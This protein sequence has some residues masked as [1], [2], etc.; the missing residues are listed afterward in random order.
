MMTVYDDIMRTIIDLPPDQLL[1]LDAWRLSLGLS[2]A[3]AVRRAVSKLLEAERSQASALDASFG[4]LKGRVEDG[5]V[6]QE[7]LRAEWDDR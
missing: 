5:L 4:L 1:A 2:R 3:E 6:V 7:R